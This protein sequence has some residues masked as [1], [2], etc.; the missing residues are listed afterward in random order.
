M[1]RGR[2]ARPPEAEWSSGVA[3]FW[4]GGYDQ[5]VFKDKKKNVTT[6]LAYY[7]I[8]AGRRCRVLD[9]ADGESA[10]HHS[11][12]ADSAHGERRR[13]GTAVVLAVDAGALVVSCPWLMSMALFMAQVDQKQFGSL[14]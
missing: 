3:A 11:R 13:L 5:D 7:I 10:G 2:T 12:V 14:T 6:T 4:E 8:S 9:C 1:G